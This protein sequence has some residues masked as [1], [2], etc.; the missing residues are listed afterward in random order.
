MTLRK[1]L[2]LSFLLW[3]VCSAF[4]QP[5]DS[6]GQREWSLLVVPLVFY[7][8]GTD[9]SFGPASFLRYQAQEDCAFCNASFMR[10]YGYYTL[11]NQWFV[12]LDGETWFKQN[13]Y[14]LRHDLSYAITPYQFFGIGNDTRSQAR[15]EFSQD[16]ILIRLEGSKRLMA[17]KQ[18]YGGVVVDWQQ[19]RNMEVAPGGLLDNADITGQNGGNAVGT[20]L[21]VNYDT[22]DNVYFTREGF[23]VDGFL[24]GYTRALGSD[25][26]FSLLRFDVRQFWPVGEKSTLGWQGFAQF[27]SDGV[28]FQLMGGLGSENWFRGVIRGRFLD[29]HSFT[30]QLEYR[31]PLFWRLGASAFVAA[32]RVGQEPGDLL[33]FSGL[34]FAYGV[35]GRFTFDEQEHINARLDVAYSDVGGWNYYFTI[36][37]AF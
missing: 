32:G 12:R 11:A 37:E 22:R 10:L 33:R 7:T 31:Q 30:T 2:L 14:K 25:F 21:L 35:G 28:P 34:R 36:R 20:G 9:W 17:D 29:Q 16:R 3:R 23:Y 6:T 1:L 24:M 13:D 5:A 26:G 15:E 19:W 27:A 4:A 18:L 8:P